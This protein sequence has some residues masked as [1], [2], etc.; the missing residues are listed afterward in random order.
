MKVNFKKFNDISYLLVLSFFVGLLSIYYYGD[1]SIDHEWSTLLDNLYNHGT[2]AFRSFDGNL[3]PSVY[4]P[5]LY[6]YFLYL[7]K[8]L[9]P[10][11]F[12][13]IHSVLF[14]QV[15]LS[16][17][18]IYFF[19]KLNRFF[20]SKN[21]SLLNSFIL[22]IFPLKVYAMTQISSVT[23]QFFLLTLY[24]YLFFCLYKSKS[25][26]KKILVFFSI[27]SGLLILLRGEFYLI[28]I[29][30]LIY[31]FF[32]KKINLK[33]FFIIFLISFIVASPYI[34]RNYYTFEKIALT[35]SL[36]YNLWK[37][38]N[39]FASVEGAETSEAFSHNNINEKIEN[40]PKNKLYD[41]YYDKMFFNEG[42]NYILADPI[43]FVK[44][45]IKKVFSFFYFNTNSD[46]PNYYHPLFIFPII[47]TSLLSS[48][49]IFFSFKKMD[50]DKGFLLF[51]L[52]FNILLFSVFFI[53]PRYKMI[54][55]PVQLIF[56]NYFFLECFKKISFL[57]KFFNIK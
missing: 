57:N 18:S 27:I 20:F 56:M 41:F 53:L 8:I 12:L 44:N 54:I 22:S 3:I 24:L 48:V 39:P 55:L 19:F 11:F 15:I 14:I 10:N 40:L 38:N 46:Y 34:L 29:L 9:N 42:I 49:G 52:F 2:L 26:K 37:G 17:L 47:L 45:Y 28:F 50:F 21:L 5:P 43:L 4:M 30:S 33:F 7:I 36:G 16:T 23:L 13:Y 32:F 6:V 35:K 31:L 1:T 51:Y 25:N